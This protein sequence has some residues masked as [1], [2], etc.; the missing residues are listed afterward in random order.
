MKKRKG[1]TAAQRQASY[2]S[3][4]R[5]KHLGERIRAHLNR[6]TELSR[7]LAAL[8]GDTQSEIITGG[9]V[10]PKAIGDAMR[11]LENDHGVS[12]ADQMANH[13][14]VGLEVTSRAIE[15]AHKGEMDPEKAADLM[16]DISTAIARSAV[17]LEADQKN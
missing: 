15:K 14:R 1:R 13:F 6:A 9:I 8:S 10:V 17:R 12:V 11:A 4:E 16:D 7:E 3:R 5:Y 2:R